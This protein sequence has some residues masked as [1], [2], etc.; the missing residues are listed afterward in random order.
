MQVSI[1]PM[2]AVTED[3]Q[4]PTVVEAVATD[5]G[6]PVREHRPQ[7]VSP[8]PIQH[9]LDEVHQGPSRHIRLRGKVLS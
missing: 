5:I 2:P 9:M 1:A 6:A 4:A 8:E 3:A 7:L